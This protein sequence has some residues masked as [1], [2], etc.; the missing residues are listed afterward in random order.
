MR[1]KKRKPGRPK[2]GEGPPRER[3][4]GKKCDN[5]GAVEQWASTRGPMITETLKIVW[6]R[7]KVCN[8]R[9]RFEIRLK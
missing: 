5:C 1:K 8:R 6:L 2:D 3:I 7:C 9:K 4:D